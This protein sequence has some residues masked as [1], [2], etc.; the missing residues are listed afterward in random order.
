MTTSEMNF[1]LSSYQREQAMLDLI[2]KPCEKIRSP[3][4]NFILFLEQE[5][6]EVSLFMQ[7]VKLLE[8][9]SA[10]SS[11]TAQRLVLAVAREQDP[12]MQR[13]Y[14]VEIQ[15]R[16][17]HASKKDRRRTFRAVRTTVHKILRSFAPRRRRGRP[18]DSAQFAWRSICRVP[19]S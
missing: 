18:T 14:I 3:D 7:Q 2:F 17:R 19:G 9:S 4:P 6:R 10:D 1:E 8:A 16:L 11:E 12:Q 5:K 15:A 13:R